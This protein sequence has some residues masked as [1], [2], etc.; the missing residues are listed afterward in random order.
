MSLPPFTNIPG[1]ATCQ[2]GIRVGPSSIAG[3]G[4][5]VF[6]LEDVAAGG[7]IFSITEPLLNIVDDEAQSLS[8]TCDNCFAAKVD[9]LCTVDDL[10]IMFTA[11]SGCQVLHYCSEAC[12]TTAWNHHHQ[13][14]CKVYQAILKHPDP[15]TRS[16]IS[17]LNLRSIIRVLE[18]H[19]HHRIPEEEWKEIL[20]LSTGRK[21]K[22]KRQE[23]ASDANFVA[24][25]AKTFAMSEL[26]IDEIIDLFCAFHNNQLVIGL[27]LLR[28]ERCYDPKRYSV[29]PGGIVLEPLAAMMNHSC[30]ANARWYS[31]GKELRI[32]ARTDVKAGDELTICYDPTEDYTL[33]RS[34]LRNFDIDCTCPICQNGDTGPAG[35]FRRNI[36]KLSHPRPE[37]KIPKLTGL[38]NAIEAMKQGEYGYGIY[39]M[40]DLHQ[41]TYL[42][43][44]RRGETAECLKVALKIYY[45][46]EP[47]IVPPIYEDYRL[48]TLYTVVS[49]LNPSTAGTTDLE[50]L[51]FTLK[52]I[53]PIIFIHLRSKIAMDTER[54]YGADSIVARFE[55][56]FFIDTLKRLQEGANVNFK[57]VAADTDMEER[58]RFVKNINDLLQWAGI[59]AR[60]ER[61][62]V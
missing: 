37:L 17:K 42:T 23:F 53:I 54:C 56:Q 41:Q 8:H 22:M 52:E 55:R 29:V 10:D 19:K 43:H 62:L 61:D 47:T 58:A 33:R 24:M 46:I 31:N 48:C 14:E 28:G 15:T 2:I 3:A 44:F 51:P 59:N 5:G 30:S 6:A 18:L 45:V 1:R 26:T 11:C 49:L 13:F 38:A 50:E 40:R 27:P 25:V 32:R 57:Y 7:P 4:R 35:P 39:P 34:H 36:F 16:M 21:S 20:S 12:Q 60:T 9:E